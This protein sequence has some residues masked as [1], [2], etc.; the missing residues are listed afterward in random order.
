M[1]GCVLWMALG[2]QAQSPAAM[3]AATTTEAA[4]ED[5]VVTAWEGCG[6]F[7]ETLSGVVPLIAVEL[8]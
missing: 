3:P 8:R 2:M 1:V 7:F 5:P 4:K 6:V